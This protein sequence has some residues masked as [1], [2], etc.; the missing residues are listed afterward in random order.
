[1]EPWQWNRCSAQYIFPQQRQN[2][3]FLFHRVSQ[4]S[5]K[6]V[7]ECLRRS[8]DPVD[9][10]A[11]HVNSQTRDHH[12]SAPC[13]SLHHHREKKASHHDVGQHVDFHRLEMLIR[14]HCVELPNVLNACVIHEKTHV[15]PVDLVANLL[16]KLNWLV[17]PEISY[18][19]IE[20]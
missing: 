13:L 20:V 9:G 11:A 4:A 17:A 18:Y 15:E 1:M 2:V 14:F 7:I 3:Y 5:S 16:V 19:V 8:V 6:C 12:Y 10:T